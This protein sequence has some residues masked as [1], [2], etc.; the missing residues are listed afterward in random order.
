M[1]NNFRRNIIGAPCPT[2]VQF[3]APSDFNV[4][5]VF[6]FSNLVNNGTETPTTGGARTA[7]EDEGPQREPAKGPRDGDA[8]PSLMIHREQTSGGDS[9]SKS[10]LVEPDST[11][12]PSPNLSAPSDAVVEVASAPLVGTDNSAGDE[13]ASGRWISERSRLVPSQSGA[14]GVLP[15]IVADRLKSTFTRCED[16]PIHIP[17]AIQRFGALIALKYNEAG[18]LEARICSENSLDILGYDPEQLFGLPS[19][20]D[21]VRLEDRDDM[22]AIISHVLSNPILP[23]QNVHPDVLPVSI[24]SPDKT[25]TSLW[26]AIHIS[27]SSKGLII[28][29]FEYYTEIFYDSDP[30]TA[31]NLRAEPYA[32]IDMDVSPEELARSTS[33]SKPLGAIGVAKRRKNSRLSSM[34]TFNAM[35][36]AQEQLASATSVQHLLDIVVGLISELTCFH[37]VMIY[38]FDEEKNGCVEAELLDP[39]AS[40]DLF[41]GK[42]AYHRRNA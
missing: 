23:G 42:I 6:P 14:P 17:G 12:S 32:T 19:F 28:C 36:Q 40:P 13:K 30:N 3:L 38:R 29:E 41:R 21:I 20:L 39:K 8:M 2:P 27:P 18:A 35:S 34:D 1:P 7:R 10:A 25:Q 26:C 31:V 37:R 4:E 33:K 24:I 9:E 5:R 11:P 16:E 15:G 22:T